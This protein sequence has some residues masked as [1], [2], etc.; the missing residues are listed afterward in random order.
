MSLFSFFSSH[1]VDVTASGPS[2]MV[3]YREGAL[4]SHDFY[5][6]FSG[7][8]VVASVSVPNP[9]TW[10][11]TIPWAAGRRDEVLGRVAEAL[12]RRQCH[13]CMARVGDEWMDLVLVRLSGRR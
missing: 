10:D 1:S 7:G 6:E 2:G 4:H 13:G 8:D 9:A 3:H 11:R 5:W 12:C